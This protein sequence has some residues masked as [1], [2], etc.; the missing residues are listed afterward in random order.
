MPF[1]S[2]TVSAAIWGQMLSRGIRG[3]NSKDLADAIAIACSIHFL[4][5]GTISLTLTGTAAGPGAYL[6]VPI[7]GVTGPSMSALMLGKAAS[8][9]FKGKTMKD[10]F[11][12]ISLGVTMSL[13]S[14]VVSGVAVGVG[15]GTGVGRITGF[16][17]KVLEGLLISQFTSKSIVG[18]SMKDL[19]EIVSTG[20]VNCILSTAVVNVTVVGPIVP[21][22]TGPIAVVGVPNI[23]FFI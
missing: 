7:V 18:K 14:L 10:L 12:G 9:G 21:P 2:T 5:P 4:T 6:S 22:P 23:A 13:T 20:I 16:N 1:P 3:K 15:I 19:A 8:K 17:Q 11:D